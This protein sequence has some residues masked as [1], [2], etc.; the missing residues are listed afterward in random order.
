MQSYK[1]IANGNL[2]NICKIRYYR[3]KDCTVYTKKNGLILKF[4]R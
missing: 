3:A 2:I 4:L 1:K